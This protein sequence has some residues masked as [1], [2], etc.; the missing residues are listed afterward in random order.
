MTQAK[1]NAPKD[2]PF[3]LVGNK[4]DLEDERAVTEK[5]GDDFA[6][7]LG[8]PFKEVSALTKD[9]IDDMFEVMV[10]KI[11]PK[12]L[13]QLEKKDKGRTTLKDKK[14]DDKGDKG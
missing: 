11:L 14:K 3:M 5:E 7:E 8:Y 12:K 9:N 1:E 6:K 13:E 10:Q 2:V 4:N